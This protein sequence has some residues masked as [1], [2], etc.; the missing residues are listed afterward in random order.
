MK[1]RNSTDESNWTT[2]RTFRIQPDSNILPIA[3]AAEVNDDI[4]NTKVEVCGIVCGVRS[5]FVKISYF[6]N[7]LVKESP[8]PPQAKQETVQD[9]LVRNNV[10]EGSKVGTGECKDLINKMIKNYPT[11][12]SGND[13]NA[14]VL[15]DGSPAKQLTD[16]NQV[17]RC[18]MLFSNVGVPGKSAHSMVVFSVNEKTNFITV[19]EQNWDE[20]RFVKPRDINFLS[21]DPST[22]YFVN[23]NCNK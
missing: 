11:F 6:W 16:I 7:S 10:P 8:A 9:F 17:S 4:Y 15:K 23:A 2:L 1:V 22:T 18:S 3:K 12:G 13:A 21:L 5:V 14:Y 19:V 20:K